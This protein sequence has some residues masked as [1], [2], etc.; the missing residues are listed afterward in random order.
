MTDICYYSSDYYAPYT[1]ISMYSLCKNNQDVD[2]MLHCIDTGI[3]DE[4]KEKML[5]LAESFGKTLVFHDYSKLEDYIKNDL[6]L[7]LCGGSYA[8]YIKVFPE[9]IFPDAEKIL[10][11]DG[12][13]II[14]GSIKELLETDIDPYVFAAVKVPLI[15]ESRIYDID[16]S[17]NLRFQYGKKFFNT[18]Y[19]N[20]GIFYANLKRWKEV[21]FGAQIMKMK[22]E[23][24]DIISK[25]KDV[26]IDE[27]LLNLAALEHKD[28]NYALA[29]PSIYNATAHN[30]PHHRALKA[31]LRCGYIDKADFNRAYYHPVIIHYCI[32]KPWFTDCYTRY[33]KTVKK[34]RAESPWPDA[35]TEKMYDTPI[36]V[37]FGKMVHACQFEWA[38]ALL[39]VIG[40]FFLR[41]RAR[42]IGTVELWKARKAARAEQR[43]QQREL[44]R[45]RAQLELEHSQQ[46][47]LE[48]SRQRELERN[49]MYLTFAQSRL[50][51]ATKRRWQSM[52]EGDLASAFHFPYRWSSIFRRSFHRAADSLYRFFAKAIYGKYFYKRINSEDSYPG[53][54]EVYSVKDLYREMRE[55]PLESLALLEDAALCERMRRECQD[56]VDEAMAEDLCVRAKTTL[57]LLELEN[58]YMTPEQREI[59]SSPEK[60]RSWAVNCR[61]V[62]FAENLSVFGDGHEIIPTVDSWKKQA[63]T[64][65]EL[66]RMMPQIN[67]IVGILE[68]QK[69]RQVYLR[70]VLGRLRFDPY[71]FASGFD[72]GVSDY[73]AEGFPLQAGEGIVDCGAYT[74]DTL[75]DFVDHGFVPDRYYGFEPAKETFAEL[76]ETTDRLNEQYPI[77]IEIYSFGVGEKAEEVH[78]TANNHMGNC[79]SDEGEETVKIVAVDSIV[80]GPV[81]LIKYDVEG[82]ELE[83]LKGSRETILKNRP[84]LAVSLYHKPEDLTEIPMYIMDNFPFYKHY[85]IRQHA[86]S[87][88][89]TIL[90]VW[91]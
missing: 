6:K 42:F 45:N 20:I 26:P 19:Y 91:E 51:M 78:F 54:R 18:G 40:H 83:A 60:L 75:Q 44:E 82:Y 62:E 13:T 4:N 5:R 27:M 48:R 73:F 12:D 47:E 43:R 50:A 24:L 49:Q 74:G 14:N 71:L 87:I 84:K 77:D 32:F 9:K 30:F 15:N 28:E 31:A 1:G 36:N 33:K 72:Y 70:S 34:Y 88:Y 58:G 53:R 7:P 89:E 17:D 56:A 29:L 64:D 16:N 59:Y 52:R 46:R 38:M 80:D 25:A 23:H 39:R 79:V 81:S 11:M 90:Y 3:S 63:V 68:D 55:N 65:S 22:D 61:W 85:M 57:E 21:D 67:R 8:T 37:Y 76:L 69:S 35:F 10:F 86:Y 41:T 66:M 2:F